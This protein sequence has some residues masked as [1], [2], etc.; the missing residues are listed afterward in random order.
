MAKA[1]KKDAAER[2]ASAAALAEDLRRYLDF[3]PIA[4]GLKTE[5]A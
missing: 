2:Y 3:A 5:H 1:L 4:A